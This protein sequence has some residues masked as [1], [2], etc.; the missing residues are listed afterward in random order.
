M[1]SFS[2]N[3]L[4]AFLKFVVD[5]GVSTTELQ[6]ILPALTGR[7]LHELDAEKLLRALSPSP[8]VRAPKMQARADEK[9]SKLTIGMATYDDYDG[10]Y[11]TL[12]A[13]R[14]YHPEIINDVEFI[15]IDN[16]PDGPCAQALKEL[17][18]WISNYRYIAKGA[19]F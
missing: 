7:R 16:N 19:I 3:R 15:I 11:F 2:G 9:T 1:G 13:I 18:N 4:D 14:L 17:G 6:K 12:Q 10:V 8:P 5:N